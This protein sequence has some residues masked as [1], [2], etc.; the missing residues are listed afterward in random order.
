LGEVLIEVRENW[1]MIKKIFDILIHAKEEERNDLEGP[2]SVPAAFL[3][4]LLTAGAVFLRSRA[5]PG[6]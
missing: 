3:S 4:E 1:K 2:I 5:P 6:K